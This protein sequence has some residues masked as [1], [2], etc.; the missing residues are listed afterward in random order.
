MKRQRGVTLVELVATIVVI[1]MAGSALVGTLSYLANTSSSTMRQ[2]QAQAIA[3]AY[4]AEIVGKGFTDPDGI[5]GE[6]DR[7]F[8]D[9]V[10]DYN[11]YTAPEPGNFEVRVAVSAG[12]LTGIPNNAVRRVDVSVDYDTNAFAMATGYRTNR[13]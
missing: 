8:F 2:T 6:T 1:S 3:D 5:N 11:G 10:L 13:P 12:T 4:L 7:A 9:D